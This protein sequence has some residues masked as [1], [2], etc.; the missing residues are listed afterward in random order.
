MRRALMSFVAVGLLASPVAAVVGV[1]VHYGIDA[2]L[3]M[4][5]LR[6]ESLEFLH[7]QLNTVE[8][9]A[10]SQ[11]DISLL[12]QHLRDMTTISGKDI[13][14]YVDRI[15]W[16]R[17][18]L[19]IGG[20]VYIDAI[21]VIDAI[22]LS[23]NFAMWEYL[24][25]IRYPNGVDPAKLTTAQHL[26]DVFTYDSLPVT[27]DQFDIGYGPLHQTPYTKLHFDLTVRK[28]VIKV[29][30][31]MKIFRLYAGGGAT[32]AFAT[33]LLSTSL[34]EKA[35]GSDLDVTDFNQ[36][37]SVVNVQDNQRKILDEII[38]SLMTPHF[39][40]HLV[41]GTMIKLPVIPLGFYVDGKLMIPFGDI[42]ENL[43]RAGFGFL[44][45]GGVTLGL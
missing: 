11:F 13:P 5:D 2:T 29:P 9:F 8:Q 40:M 16:K 30:K 32:L 19:N 41:V 45:N 42:D 33:P 6:G 35:L 15:D 4:K 21:P 43:D 31:K 7:F 28:N 27:L 10:P 14:L 1:G 25:Q 34:V 38:N 23:M 44:V 24:G 36:L 3:D 18:P 39:G 22:E 17:S 37:M 20:K 12:P 26:A